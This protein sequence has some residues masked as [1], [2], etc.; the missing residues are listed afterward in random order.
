MSDHIDTR[1]IFIGRVEFTSGKI[2]ARYISVDLLRKCSDIDEAEKLS[3]AFE[4]KAREIPRHIGFVYTIK[5]RIGE[6]GRM[7]GIQGNP[8]G[9]TDQDTTGIDPEWF[10]YWQAQ[11]RAKD[12]SERVKKLEAKYD[13]ED[14]RRRLIPL[15][16]DYMKTDK[17][18]RLALEVVVLDILRNG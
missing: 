5:A 15:K 9:S 7:M 6:D 13:R 4:L 14:L 3:S 16:A 18:G 2:G 12:V 17:I 11:D 8:F 1:F 10:A